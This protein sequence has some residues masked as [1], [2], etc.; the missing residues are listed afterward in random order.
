MTYS[1]AEFLALLLAMTADTPDRPDRRG[2]DEIANDMRLEQLAEERAAVRRGDF[3]GE[4]SQRWLAER[5]AG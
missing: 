3:D 5:R 4:R 1:R 2:A